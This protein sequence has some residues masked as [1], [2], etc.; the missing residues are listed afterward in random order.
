[1][2]VHLHVRDGG[3]VVEGSLWN[4]RDLVSVQGQDSEV[5][6]TGQSV[7]L[8]TLQFIVT[9]DTGGAR[10]DS[11]LQGRSRR[12]PQISSTYRVDNLVRLAKV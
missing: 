7:T 2:L 11:K 9:D 6:Q 5:L 1:M 8:D 12:M 3:Q 4:H 10:G